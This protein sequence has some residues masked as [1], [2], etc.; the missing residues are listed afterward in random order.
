MSQLQTNVYL[1]GRKN[2]LNTNRIA[3]GMRGTEKPSAPKR[4]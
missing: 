4:T 3:A 2:A 1:H